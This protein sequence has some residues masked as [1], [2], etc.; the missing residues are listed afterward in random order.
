MAVRVFSRVLAMSAVTG[1][2]FG[3]AS[4]EVESVLM[5]ADVARVIDAFRPLPETLDRICERV[6]GLCGYRVAA[7][8]LPTPEGDALVF[9][10]SSG[11]SPGYRDRVNRERPLR[12]D[13]AGASGPGPTVT[14]YQSG[15]SVTIGDLEL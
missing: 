11:M 1:P 7:L 4:V 12:L 14:A 5:I 13:D 15:E 2:G 6:R 3:A 9:A 10:G 8:L